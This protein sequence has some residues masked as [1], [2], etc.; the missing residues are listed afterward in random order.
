[1][2]RDERQYRYHARFR[3]VRDGIKFEHVRSPPLA[4]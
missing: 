1:M 2:G 4:A 3:E